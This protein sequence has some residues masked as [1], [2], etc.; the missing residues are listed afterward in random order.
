MDGKPWLYG[1]QD[2]NR[3]GSGVDPATTGTAIDSDIPFETGFPNPDGEGNKGDK[4]GSGNSNTGGGSTGEDPV[5]FNESNFDESYSN[6]TRVFDVR[7]YMVELGWEL[8]ESVDLRSVRWLGMTAWGDDD[9][10]DTRDRRDTTAGRYKEIASVDFQDEISG[11][12]STL[13]TEGKPRHPFAAAPWDPS[14]VLISV[15]G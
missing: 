13:L 7:T 12:G 4:I 14:C 3:I 5:S 9:D 1:R 15:M 2:G 11:S 8:A 6:F 10:D